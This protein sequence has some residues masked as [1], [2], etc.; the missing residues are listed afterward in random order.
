MKLKVT[1]QEFGRGPVTTHKFST[2][3]GASRFIQSYWQGTEYMD[4]AVSFHT[5]YCAYVLHGF[6][7]NDIGDFI[8]NFEGD[9][10]FSFFTGRVMKKVSACFAVRIPLAEDP[11]EIEAHAPVCD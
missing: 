8:Y 2:L 7:L 6:T 9:R 1:S 5:D 11:A 10:T 3:N 4:G